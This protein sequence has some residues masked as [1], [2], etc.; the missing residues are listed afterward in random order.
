MKNK[1]LAILTG[2]MVISAAFTFVACSETIDLTEKL[3]RS[4]GELVVATVTVKNEKTDRV[5][6]EEK[7]FFET[8]NRLPV[9]ERTSGATF[10]N[11]EN[12]DG[13]EFFDVNGRQ[14]ETIKI[15]NDLTLYARYE[16][17][18]CTI[19]FNLNGGEFVGSGSDIHLYYMDDTPVLPVAEK[20]GFLFMGWRDEAGKIVSDDQG[21]PINIE[22]NSENY[23]MNA[24][25]ICRLTAV[26]DDYQPTVTFDFND[27][28]IQNQTITVRYNSVINTPDDT[29]DTGSR[30]IVGWSTYMNE[31][32]RD[33]QM[34]YNER[35]TSDITLYAVWDSYREVDLYYVDDGSRTVLNEY[36]PEKF[37]VFST[38]DVAFPTKDEVNAKYGFGASS[39]SWY[40]DFDSYGYFGEKVS[41]PKNKQNVSSFYGRVMR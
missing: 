41:T 13:M 20:E 34:D 10:L 15:K 22:F 14:I 23:N 8:D 6:L 35:V 24:S 33:A 29:H 11:Y 5:I 16:Y 27:G 4:N 40:D 3:A 18:S 37:K 21:N 2:I 17:K 12:K 36:D 9:P 25:A 7:L 19:T 31:S 1:I 26:F 39:I 30:M 38:K 32:P 28:S